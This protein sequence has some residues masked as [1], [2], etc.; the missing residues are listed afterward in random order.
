MATE[1]PALLAAI[2]RVLRNQRART[3]I[4]ITRVVGEHG[5]VIPEEV[6]VTTT[7]PVD[8]PIRRLSAAQ[9]VGVAVGTALLLVG[10]YGVFRRLR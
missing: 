7:E 8:E 6:V 10:A 4:T 1:S 5:E 2:R 3:T 9:L